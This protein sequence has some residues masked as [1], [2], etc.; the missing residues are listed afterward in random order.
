MSRN[1]GLASRLHAALAV[2]VACLLCTGAATADTLRVLPEVGRTEFLQ[3]FAEA[4]TRIRI[5]ICVLEDPQILA[6]LKQALE[7]GVKVQVI[8]DRGKY[9]ALQPERTNLANYVVA[10]GGELHLSNAIFPRSFPKIILIDGRK[11]IMGS[12]CLDTTTFQQYRDYFVVSYDRAVFRD[13]SALF[14]NDWQYSSVP[15]GDEV[16]FNPTPQL[17]AA[18]LAVGPVNAASR[19]TTFIQYARRSLDVTTELLGNAALESELVA[20]VRR[21]VAVR[22]ISPLCV[23]GATPDIRTLQNASL[24]R[25]QE[26][27]VQVHV[28]GPGQTFQKPYMHAR[29]MLADGGRLYIGSISFSPDSST[30]NREA[31]LFM[32]DWAAVA[33]YRSRFNQDFA[34]NSLPYSQDCPAT[35]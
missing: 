5:E 18:P 22:L 11:F 24:K 7:R 19:L 34:A 26:N 20:A 28:T 4:R 31:G 23:N 12:A 15:G 17:T 32:Y 9:E 10:S 27:G 16:P 8:V 33:V 29:S 1:R 6:G 30:F 21:G 25:L 35:P 3:A 14:D 13:L 2:I